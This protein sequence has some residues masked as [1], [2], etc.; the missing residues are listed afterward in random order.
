MDRY[1]E[2][3][4]SAG[5][6]KMGDM[7][8]S[9][10]AAKQ[11]HVDSPR[12]SEEEDLDFAMANDVGPSFPKVSISHRPTELVI[13]PEVGE[14]EHMEEEMLG[15]QDTEEISDGFELVSMQDSLV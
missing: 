13:H 6:K 4:G 11:L 1:K 3:E 9:R 14:D 10:P 15:S 8:G 5:N 12:E 7:T 2:T